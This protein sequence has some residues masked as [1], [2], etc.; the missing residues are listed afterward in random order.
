[1]EKTIAHR[2]LSA[3]LSFWLLW[4]WV[5]NGCI[6]RGFK[7][8]APLNPSPDCE[9][10]TYADVLDFGLKS[11]SRMPKESL[12][13]VLYKLRGEWFYTVKHAKVA[14]KVAFVLADCEQDRE[15]QKALASEG[16]RWGEIGFSLGGY[17]DAELAYYYAM[18][19]G[20]AVQ[21]NPLLALKN[22]SRIEEK[23]RDAIR[24]DPSVDMG[25]PVR[26]LAMLYLKAPPWPQGPGDPDKALML[27]RW[28]S[29]HFGGHPLNHIFLA[30]AYLEVIGEDAN[31]KIAQEIRHALALMATKNYGCAQQAWRNMAMEILEEAGIEIEDLGEKP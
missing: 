19:L 24:L 17:K 13:C 3:S 21:D 1:V 2:F 5:G 6:Y 15:R 12:E 7:G 31:Q 25:G 22:I 4:M 20:L 14:C 8:Q 18:N 16:A 30:R 10:K 28:A 11:S 26:V 23:L 9:Q 29:H 27:L